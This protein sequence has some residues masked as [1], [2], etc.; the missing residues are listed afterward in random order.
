MNNGGKIVAV[1][2]YTFWEIETDYPCWF[3]FTE[4]LQKLFNIYD[5]SYSDVEYEFGVKVTTGA[6]KD[7]KVIVDYSNYSKDEMVKNVGL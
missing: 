3:E 7:Y 4:W 6:I 1:S 5:S 2:P